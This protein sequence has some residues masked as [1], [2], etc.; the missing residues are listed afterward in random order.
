MEKSNLKRTLLIAVIVSIV[1]V[2]IP[3]LA[4]IYIEG[5]LFTGSNYLDTTTIDFFGSLIAVFFII[6]GFSRMILYPNASL[7]A[8]ATRILRV[9]IGF[10]ILSLHIIPFLSR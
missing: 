6:E 5:K 8:Q 4:Q 3:I 9:G 10:S 2:S 7:R 1:F